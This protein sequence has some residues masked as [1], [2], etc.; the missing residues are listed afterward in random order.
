MNKFKY[1]KNFSEDK[2]EATILLYENIGNFIEEDGT[3]VEGISGAEFASTLQYLEDFG[4]ETV[5]VRIN[6]QGGSV[7]DGFSIVSAIK[8]SKMEIHTYNDGL[9]ASIAAVIFAS[10][11]YRHMMDYAITMIHN[12]S[13][14]ED[15]E[16]LTRV[17]DSLKTI[18][19]NNSVYTLEELDKLMNSETYFNALESMSSGICDDIIDSGEKVEV[20]YEDMT[21]MTNVFNKLINK[22]DMKKVTKNRMG[23]ESPKTLTNEEEVI[24]P[25]QIVKEEEKEEATEEETVVN[26]SEEGSPEEVNPGEGEPDA[27]E[28][29][30]TDY[31][32]MLADL[33]E[34]HLAMNSEMETMKL[35]NDELA[36]K[37]EKMK[38]E[39]KKEHK[40]KIDEMVNNL[41]VAGKIGKTEIE[42]VTNLAE[43][44]FE[45]VKTLFNRVGL[46]KNVSF[47][48]V[49]DS[50]TTSVNGLEAGWTIRDYEKKNPARLGEIKN[51]LPGVYS[52]LY[53]D[54]YGVEPK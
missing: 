35:A 12:P 24:V 32:A 4:I 45:S 14:T 37:L 2:T 17:K 29:D 39:V 6:S 16:I 40:K 8:N 54:F 51:N 43:K 25:I 46:V 41:F 22:L 28:D 34:K 19:Q 3:K 48:S 53:K 9:C 38:D 15:N 21:E 42:S 23:L 50:S 31:K 36:S 49:I 1:I 10:G 13:G 7:M 20:Q 26:S 44:D 5:H 33:T 30:V 11:D 27:D 52:Q 18:L 47:K